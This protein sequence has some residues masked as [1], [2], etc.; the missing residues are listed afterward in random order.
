[1]FNVDARLTK[2]CSNVTN[3]CIAET[4]LHSWKSMKCRKSKS[5]CRSAPQTQIE[6]YN[7]NNNLG[8]APC[9]VQRAGEEHHLPAGGDSV[10]EVHSAGIQA[11]GAHRVLDQNHEE[12]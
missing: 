9:P 2:V 6:V 8:P 10:V 4:V 11:G 7:P 3:I 5:Y 1:M 12:E